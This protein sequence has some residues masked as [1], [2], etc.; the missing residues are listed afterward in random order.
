MTPTPTLAVYSS[1]TSRGLAN[2]LVAGLMA[3]NYFDAR[4]LDRRS[5]PQHD[6]SRGTAIVLV[7]SVDATW[8]RGE[9]AAMRD[10]VLVGGVETSAT[11]IQALSAG[12][13]TVVNPRVPFDVL[14]EEL[15]AVLS[16]NDAQISQDTSD[17]IRRIR[18]RAQ[19]AERVDELTDREFE[20]L[21][22]LCAGRSAETLAHAL[23]I[24]VTTA[25][26]HIRHILH[27]LD[28][29]SQIAACALLHRSGHGLRRQQLDLHIGRY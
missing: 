11:L 9:L 27:K 29:H 1:A 10:A 16:S 22:M 14:L 24:S 28:V 20:V 2:A 17:M 5:L 7:S 18:I 26:A 12:A 21:A 19:E 4:A 6:L 13:R 23:H 8:N 3:R 25:R 15:H